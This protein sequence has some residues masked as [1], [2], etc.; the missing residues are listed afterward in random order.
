MTK[1]NI[2]ILIG[3]VTGVLMIAMAIHLKVR[4]AKTPSINTIES[5]EK[6][7]SPEA[8]AVLSA[9]RIATDN[10]EKSKAELQLLIANATASII[11]ANVNTNVTTCWI[12]HGVKGA[13]AVRSNDPNQTPVLLGFRQDGLVLW[14]YA[15]DKP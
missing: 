10:L 14:K 1:T 9:I 15:D 11:A 4:E 8:K 2:I 6:D 5:V 7:F 3:F 13:W 12:P